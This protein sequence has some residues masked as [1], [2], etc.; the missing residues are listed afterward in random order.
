ML[1]VIE[2]KGRKYAS[3]TKR[4][5]FLIDFFQENRIHYF[6]VD[7]CEAVMVSFMKH[8]FP[9]LYLFLIESMQLLLLFCLASRKNKGVETKI[10]VNPISP[11]QCAV[12]VTYNY[13][14]HLSH[15]WKIILPDIPLQIL[16]YLF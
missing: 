2:T 10:F 15:S 7:F 14:S 16:S 6:H 13:H 8:V 12:C 3:G 11:A 9:A 1:D 4:K 5:K